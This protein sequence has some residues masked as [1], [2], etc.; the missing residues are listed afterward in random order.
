[1]RSI[2]PALF[3]FTS[4][5]S[6]DAPIRTEHPLVDEQ[7]CIKSCPIPCKVQ[8]IFRQEIVNDEDEPLTT[9]DLNKACAEIVKEAG[10]DARKIKKELKT[11]LPEA[12]DEILAYGLNVLKH[13]LAKAR[14]VLDYAVNGESIWDTETAEPSLLTSTSAPR[15]ASE[16]EIPS[17]KFTETTEPSLLTST[18]APRKAYEPEVPSKEFTDTAE[19]YPSAPTAAISETYEPK[20]PNDK[21]ERVTK[22]A[23]D[24][25]YGAVHP[26]VPTYTSVPR[27]PYESE[28]PVDAV[29]EGI[30]TMITD[31]TYGAPFKTEEQLPVDF[32]TYTYK[33]SNK[34]MQHKD[35]QGAYNAYKTVNEAQ[36]PEDNKGY[37][38]DGRKG[39]PQQEK[40]DYPQQHH[41]NGA[42]HHHHH[43]FVQPGN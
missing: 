14:E 22:K 4:A 3:L 37:Y 5:V 25:G 40:K 32:P 34:A 36:E 2:A 38:R 18:S 13:D 17:K 26:Y 39:H 11:L 19:S 9:E 30:K 21:P 33:L 7:K 43:R 41:Y 8:R 12:K 42:H 35:V 28:I 1:M 16:L 29:E 20:L 10:D 15:E 24:V 23:A 6:Y 31:G 27:I